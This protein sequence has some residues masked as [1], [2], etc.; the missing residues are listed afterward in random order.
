[1][2]YL[3]CQPTESGDLRFATRVFCRQIRGHD[4]TSVKNLGESF[5]GLVKKVK[6]TPASHSGSLFG[7]QPT[8]QH[9]PTQL[10]LKLKPTQTQT[11]LKPNPTQTQLK[12]NQSQ[13]NSI[14]Q[15][16]PPPPPSRSHSTTKATH[17]TH[18][19]WNHQVRKR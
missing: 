2:R 19:R 17:E 16:T 9:N 6:K 5:L 13:S 4:A 3:I 7:Y 8:S 1:M 15:P 12:L 11:Q 14:F 18:D 10:K